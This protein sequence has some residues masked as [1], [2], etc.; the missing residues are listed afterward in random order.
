MSED[1]LP[2]IPHSV[3]CFGRDVRVLLSEGTD[4][5][6]SLLFSSLVLLGGSSVPPSSSSEKLFF[7][8][9]QILKALSNSLSALSSL[10]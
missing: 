2:L 6:R 5:I 3:L 4:S 1:F 10:H 9:S 7:F 8:T